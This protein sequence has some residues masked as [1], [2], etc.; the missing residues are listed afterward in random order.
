MVTLVVASACLTPALASQSH[1]LA[2]QSPSLASQSPALAS[3]SPALASQSPALAA[4]DSSG[5]SNS[6]K[7]DHYVRPLLSLGEAQY[8][9]D[10]VD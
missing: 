9:R 2:S 8:I 5:N 6:L 4:A 1:A 3:Q 7:D 10:I